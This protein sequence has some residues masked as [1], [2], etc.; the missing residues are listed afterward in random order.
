MRR[1][2]EMTAELN[3]A[4]EDVAA[5]GAVSKSA[6][7]SA[8]RAILNGHS[9]RLGQEAVDVS[10]ILDEYHGQVSLFAEGSAAEIAEG[11]KSRWS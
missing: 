3:A 11:D 1:V 6:I 10:R 7:R 5:L 8:V 9:A 2:K 4:I